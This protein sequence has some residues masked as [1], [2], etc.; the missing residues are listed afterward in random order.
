[1]SIFCQFVTNKNK[2]YVKQ[3]HKLCEVSSKINC[4]CPNLKGSETVHNTQKEKMTCPDQ[5]A[6]LVGQ[7]LNPSM[8]LKIRMS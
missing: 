4:P 6:G 3:E 1:L 7:F 8:W 5:Q 2:I